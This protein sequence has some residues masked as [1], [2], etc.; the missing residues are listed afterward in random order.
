LNEFENPKYEVKRSN[1]WANLLSGCDLL[2]HGLD[3]K[4][5]TARGFLSV[6]QINHTKYK[7][8]MR[9]G[10]K[11]G[12]LSIS[13]VCFWKR[14]EKKRNETKKPGEKKIEKSHWRL[15]HRTTSGQRASQFRQL[16]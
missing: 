13:F 4:V 14:K 8:T 1:R 16:K 3:A 5:N 15:S 6:I 10:Q 11:Y 7:Q 9:N 12:C 2:F